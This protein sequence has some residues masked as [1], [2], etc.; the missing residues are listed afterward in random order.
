MVVIR[1]LKKGLSLIFLL[2]QFVIFITP[3]FADDLDNIVF[4][5]TI[6]DSA[7]EVVTAAR[8]S[9]K[10]TATTIERYTQ[11]DNLGRYKLVVIEPGIYEMRVIASGFKQEERK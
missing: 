11:T 8:V 9:I 6:R 1:S 2:I 4:T 5:G 10:N 3:G 7:G